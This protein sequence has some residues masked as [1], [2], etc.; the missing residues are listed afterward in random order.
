MRQPRSIANRLALLFFAITL[1]AMVIVYAG[2]V[3]RL[4]SSLTDQRTGQLATD[5]QRLRGVIDKKLDTAAR[6]V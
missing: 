3:P 5:A 2:V 4:E 1:S 6:G